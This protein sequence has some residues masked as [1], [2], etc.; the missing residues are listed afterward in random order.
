MQIA[1]WMKI[2]YIWIDALCILQDSTQDWEHQSARMGDI[3]THSYCNIAAT[4]AEPTKGCFTYRHTPMVE[5]YSISNPRSKGSEDDPE[6]TYVIGYDDFWSNS[7]LDTPLHN[8]GWVLQER[9]LSPRTIHFGQEQMFWECRR[10]IACEAYPEGIPEQFRNWRTRAWR[11]SDEML[12]PKKRKPTRL[13]ISPLSLWQTISEYMLRIARPM[14]PKP[15]VVHLTWA[16]EIW[17]KTIERYMECKLS[18][19]EDKLV[20]ISGIAKGVANATRERY[21]A[22]LWDNALL[23]QSLLWYV[24]GRRQADSTPSTRSASQGDQNYRA[25]SWSWASLEAKLI[26]N[27]PVQC[28]KVLIEISSTFVEDFGGIKMGRVSAA[29]MTIQGRLFEA[30]LRLRNESPDKPHEEDGRYILQL[31]KI[32]R[33]ENLVEMEPTIF[34]DVPMT[35]QSTSVKTYLLPVCEEWQGRS[36]SMVTDVA[37]LLLK[38]ASAS[39]EEAK[40]ERIGIFGLDRSQAKT[41]YDIAIGEFDSV[42]T[43]PMVRNK[44]SITLV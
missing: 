30:N 26:W 7:L 44:N 24:L 23:P 16:Y 36:G 14:N 17:S 10:D 12:D 1:H 3:Y 19:S 43:R 29:S 31:S 35:T 28:G 37:G 38:R 20:A 15:P 34:L 25:P 22:G 6:E 8:R 18:F 9:L 5:P 4:G 42:E 27:W 40:Y 2:D 21:L 13:P 32:I 33:G 11:Q 39:T 41:L